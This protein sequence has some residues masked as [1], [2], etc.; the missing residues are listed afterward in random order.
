MRVQASS[1]PGI[2]AIERKHRICLLA[3]ALPEVNAFD[4]D[5]FETLRY[6]SPGNKM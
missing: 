3:P 5:D 4:F 6:G 1:E 2:K